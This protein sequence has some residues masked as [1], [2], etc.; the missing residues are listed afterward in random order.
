MEAV[1]P[2][3]WRGASRFRL[4][5]RQSQLTKMTTLMNPKWNGQFSCFDLVAKADANTGSRTLVQVRDIEIGG[6]D[7]VVRLVLV[8]LNPRTSCCGTR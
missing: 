3:R 2:A 1:Q 5:P 8:P 4:M 6:N 7:F